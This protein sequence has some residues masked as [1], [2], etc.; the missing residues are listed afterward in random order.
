MNSQTPSDFSA[1]IQ[2]WHA[3]RDDVVSN[4]V[5]AFNQHTDDNRDALKT[6][7]AAIKTAEHIFDQL[8]LFIN[9]E[10]SQF[11]IAA[12]A[13]DLAK[14]GLALITASHM[15][16]VIL[17]Q[18]PP[19]TCTP[20]LI[21]K[22]N[23]FQIIFLEKLAETREVLQLRAQEESQMVLQQALYAVPRGLR[24][25]RRQAAHGQGRPARG[26]VERQRGRVLIDRPRLVGLDSDQELL[27]RK[28][29]LGYP[30]KRGL[31]ASDHRGVF[32]S[33]GHRVRS[34]RRFGDHG[35]RGCTARTTLHSL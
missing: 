18:L 29:R 30:E 12:L 22:L 2:Q 33:G 26:R 25:P 15:M 21:N 4:M 23:N 17:P 13:S 27:S 34:L 7:L 8:T 31:A 3:L 10:V 32:R 6:S 16:R 28:D 24:A 9:E 1:I 11:D 35:Y 14:Q 5:D 20:A 19:E